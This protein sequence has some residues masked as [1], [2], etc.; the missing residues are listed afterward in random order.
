[1][2]VQFLTGLDVQGNLNLNDNQ[3]QNVIIQ[4]LGADPSGIAGKIYYNSG[5]NKLK[6]YDGSAWVDITT[7]ADGN[8][9][10]DLTATGSGNGTA[11][12]NL[13]ASNPASTDAIVY[14]G[15]GTTTVTRAGSTFTINSADQYVGTVTDVVKGKGISITGTT[16][17]TPT[18]SINYVGNGNA[19]LEAVSQSPNSEDYLW[20][21]SADDK[22]I[23][24]TTIDKMPGF[25]KDGT[26]T[27][28]ASGAGLT[29]GPITAS[30]TLE[31][32]YAGTDNVVLAAGDGTLVTLDGADKVLFSDDTDSNAKFANL[33]QVATYINAGAGSV[34]SI[35]V[36]G[37]TTGLTTSGG[38]ITTSGTI[39]LAGVLNE[40]NGGT[41][42][43]K[44][45]KGDILFADAANSLAKLAIGGSGQRLAVSSTG[46]VEWV[47]DSGSGV[48]S[49]EITETG[50]A[51]TITGGPITTSGTI[52]IAGAGSSSQVILGDLT[53]G[54][55]TTGTVTSV[56]TGAGLKGGT[57]TA[58]GTV[59]VDYGIT[60]LIEDAPQMAQ[61]PKKDDLILIQDV[62]SGKG[63]TVKQPLAKVSLSLFEAPF[64]D[65]DFASFKVTSLANGTGSKDAVNLGQVQALVAGVGVFQGGYDAAANSPA[66]A[67]AS[68]IAL[69]TGDFFVVTKDGTISFNGS[70]VDVEV[71]DTIY[72]NQ[73][74][75]A[76][77][78]PPASDYAIVIQDQNIAGVG[79]TD[80]ATEKGVAGFSSAT[81]AGTANGFITVKAGG[82][83]DAQLASTFNKQIGTST[84]LDTADVDVVDQ[85]NVTD[86]VITSMSKR[87]LPNAAT[88]S[89]GVTEIATQAEVD[90][91]TDTFRY[92]TP[93]TLAKAQAKRSYTATGPGIVT[94]SF[95]IKQSDH[96]LGNGPWIIQTYD[97]KGVQVFMHVLADQASGD[98][99]FSATNNLG[100]NTITVVMQLVG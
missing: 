56:G 71:G 73:A 37:G 60:G 74:I 98:I 3:I 99:T 51:L 92:V 23:Y 42:L 18:V 93:A 77:S 100:V 8:T 22:N 19:I 32:D 59:E 79:A 83:S 26:V 94:N 88:G 90:A 6:L 9:T 70:T 47:N 54:T 52:N 43:N 80:G 68:N 48:T 76:G 87:T 67:G 7:G 75:G 55:Y 39:T 49:I 28:I 14:T 69:T 58:T 1:M 36:S 41:G 12:L 24:K 50:N 96:K 66:I 15:S 91:G 72:A 61:G 35:D 4:P 21:S 53:L 78:N 13:V 85:I 82:I 20:F 5:T 27:S 25:G 89:V 57:I 84:N 44:Y 29:G 81:F 45:I 31:V 64:A 97:P 95:V 46:V 11:T 34:T 17:V 63:E 86:G 40:V 16:T 10:Y 62:S 30:G 38:P 33:S 65:L 2:A